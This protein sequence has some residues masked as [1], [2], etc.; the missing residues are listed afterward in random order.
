LRDL[1]LYLVPSTSER[2]GKTTTNATIERVEEKVGHHGSP[3]CSVHYDN[4]E[5]ELIGAEGQGFS[6]M[7]FMMNGARVGV[8]ME[9]I[10]VSE[11]AYRCAKDYAA[12]RKAFGVPIKRHGMIADYLDE[13]DCTIRGMRALGLEAA[14]A[15]ELSVRMEI[16]FNNGT[17]EKSDKAERRWKKMRYRARHLTPLFKYL[18]AEQAV[19]I[20]RMS[21][22]IHGGNGYTKDYAPERLL[23][24]SLVMPVYEGTSQ[25][26]CLMVLK[27]N[28][29]AILKNPQRF[30]RRVA[31]AKIQ[32]VRATDA[33]E[34][35]Y[36]K[37]QS[38]VFTAQQTI[39]WRV[40][41]NK[42]SEA[43]NSDTMGQ[44]FNKFRQDW[45]PKRD[46]SFGML[47]AEHL[48]KIM[49]DTAVAEILVKQAKDFPERRELAENWIERAEPRVRYNM[50]LLQ[51]TGERLLRRLNEEDREESAAQAG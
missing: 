25:I 19:H 40:T 45:D 12:E 21:M 29:G 39:L 44:V 43:W 7:L 5:A 23:R 17:M 27:D 47:H 42:W 30:L 2:Y 38:M 6:N 15:E 36:W 11:A 26:Q 4:A 51:N 31:R 48:T 50:D 14:F 16:A 20:C 13:M 46:F 28:L 41:K 8:G 33:L 22:Q 24:D 35:T 32:S 3:T 37:M 9:C 34:R 49:A 18:G 10:G 1:S